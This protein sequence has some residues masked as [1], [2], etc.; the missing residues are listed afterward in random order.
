MR[1]KP[2]YEAEGKLLFSKTDRVSS[3]TNPSAQVGELNGV[4]LL[5]SPL[6]TEAEIIRSNPIVK[7]TITSL[8]LTDKEG[9]PLKI[10]EFL[11]KLDV[12]SI[13]GTDI[14]AVS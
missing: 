1:Q 7:K 14:L 10:D 4:T 5:S 2:I 3:L 11:E 12:R 8:R 13:R 9:I 6:D